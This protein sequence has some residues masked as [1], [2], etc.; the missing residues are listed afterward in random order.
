MTWWNSDW[1]KKKQITITSSDALT[2]Y[3]VDL[4]VDQDADMQTDYGDLRFI[5]SSETTPLDHWVEDTSSDPASFWVKIPSITAGSSNNIYMYY[6]NATASSAVDGDNTFEF[7][8]GFTGS[9]LDTDK[10]S[11]S[12][13][14]SVSGGECTIG[15][16]NGSAWILGKTKFA[17]E[18]AF[19]TKW[20]TSSYYGAGFQY[21]GLNDGTDGRPSLATDSSF[22]EFDGN[23]DL[24][25]RDNGVSNEDPDFTMDYNY[26][27]MEM[28][29]LTGSVKFYTDSSAIGTFSS[30][31]PDASCGANF[32]GSTNYSDWVFIRKFTDPTLSPSFGAEQ[33]QSPDPVS[34]WRLDESAGTTFVE[35]T[36]GGFDGTSSRNTNLMSINGAISNGFDFNSTSDYVNCG[37]IYNSATNSFSITGW[38]KPNNTASDQGIFVKF[39]NGPGGN[40]AFD[41]N[42]GR[43]RFISIISSSG[44]PS[45]VTSSLG[46]ISTGAWQHVGIT[47]DGTT[48]VLYHNGLAVQTGSQP[49]TIKTTTMSTIIGA[50]Q[51]GASVENVFDGGLDDIRYYGEALTEANMTTLYNEGT[52]GTTYGFTASDSLSLSDA[53]TTSHISSTGYT[54]RDTESFESGFGDWVND[55][56]SDDFDWTRLTGST[57]S[58]ATG[59]DGAQDGNY[60]IYTEASAPNYPSKTASI[61]FTT[62]ASDYAYGGKVDFYYHMFGAQMGSLYFD[63]YNGSSWSNRWILSGQQQA[64][65]SD[66]YINTSS[67]FPSG[68]TKIRFRGVT[69]D[70]FT[71]DMAIDYLRVYSSDTATYSF[72]TEP[73]ADEDHF[74]VLNGSTWTQLDHF[75]KFHVKKVQNQVSEFDITIYDIQSTEKAYLKERAEVL[76][77]AGTKLILKG[78]IQNVEYG[79]A[80]ECVVQGFG[81]EALLLDQEFIKSNDKRVQYSDTSAQTVAKEILSEGSDGDSPY[82]MEPASSG[83]FT[84]DYGNLTMRYEYANRLNALGKL[85]EVID[86]SWWVS[87][88]SGDNY[89]EDSFH[90]EIP[91]GSS[92][93]TFEPSVNCIKTAQEKDVTS[94]VNSVDFLGYGDGVN[95]LQTNVY[96]ASTTS[97]TL[98]ASVASTNS[99]IVLVDATDFPNTGT[100]RIAKEQLTYAGKSGDTL[101]G[102]TRGVN[103]TTAKEHKKGCYVEPHFSQDSPETGSSISTYGLMDYTMVDKSILD[104]ATIELIASKYLIERKEPIVKINVTPDEPLE[105]AGDLNIGDT[106]TVTDTESDIDDT[107]Q[108]VGLEFDSNYGVTSM[109]VGLSNVGLNFVE[110]MQKAKERE[111]NMSKYMQGATNIY[112]LSEAEN[113]DNSNY[114]NMRFFIPNEA[115]AIN[116]VKL[117]FKMKDFRAYSSATDANS[118]GALQV[119]QWTENSETVYT[120]WT[121]LGSSGTI[122]SSTELVHV[123][124][125]TNPDL[126]TD[127][128]GL[129]VRV[130]DGINYYPSTTGEFHTV[131]R[132]TDSSQYNVLIPKDL[133]GSN[134]TIQ[135]KFLDGN[136]S[137]GYDFAV[138]THSKHTHDIA[139]GI[140]EQNLTGQSTSVY[141]GTD[142]GSMSLFGGYDVDQT[143]LDITTLVSDVGAGNWCDIQFRPN[144]LM[145]VEANAYVKVF[146]EST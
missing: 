13:T 137:V 16:T 131:S 51:D 146:I 24:N 49:A 107:Y 136:R 125:S 141:V 43:L 84:S 54:L 79:S 31:I 57:P 60:Y 12:G 62:T 34:R 3:Q 66:S 127:F 114:L 117:N 44:F 73:T 77:F 70:G 78:R 20:K 46:L 123:M 71:S 37:D 22:F 98:D 2:N 118:E 144:K 21:A 38:I 11:S 9:S 75:E 1:N 42:S 121:D 89:K 76:L 90:L 6:D 23:L 109:N 106:A 63:S 130:H 74:Y 30:Q 65:T 29:W 7:F 113:C 14:V 97:T 25:T 92:G 100:A 104:E 112:A 143:E 145:R 115:K 36:V 91:T 142:G 19:K 116:S 128:D 93:T 102:A 40:Y 35:D 87:Q 72:D 59:P 111:E 48:G 122:T 64:T 18:H 132:G 138:Y 67:T 53:I 101:T 45:S 32:R 124:L 4:S 133:S 139:F 69:G 119:K 68:T 17:P 80:Y 85:A 50:F 96:A 120:T 129:S 10:W 27:V 82:I 61:E 81:K 58:A 126:T 5:D 140:S 108:V 88:S 86:Y 83:L 33:S 110:Q 134:L 55:T 26:H 15:A 8:D 103:S 94:L 135:A 105:I 52:G 99:S 41:L 47:R 56:S 39:D 95:Q 28:E